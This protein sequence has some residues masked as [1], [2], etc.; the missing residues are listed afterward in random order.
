MIEKRKSPRAALPVKVQCTDILK[1]SKFAAESVDISQGGICIKTST[2]LKNG[3][4]ILL[5]LTLPGGTFVKAIG[6]VIWTGKLGNNSYTGG[7]YFSEI[8]GDTR[9]QIKKYVE[10]GLKKSV[11]VER[12]ACKRILLTI[13]VNFMGTEAYAKNISTSGIC[14]TC[15]EEF[16]IK[17]KAELMFFLPNNICIKVMGEIRW[18]KKLSRKQYE[19]GII[20]KNIN[21]NYVEKIRQYIG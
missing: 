13:T 11:P 5:T 8:E 20:F 19:Y 15:D 18:C 9:A 1:S 3:R 7:I 12:R 10:T 16:H 21:K 17:E 14:I 6:K 4:Y 2:E